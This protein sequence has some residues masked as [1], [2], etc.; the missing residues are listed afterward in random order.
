MYLYKED[1]LPL[2]VKRHFPNKIPN[3]SYI[4]FVDCVTDYVS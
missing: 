2:K 1:I 3:C 4:H